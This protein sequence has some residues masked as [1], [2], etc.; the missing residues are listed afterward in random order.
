MK[1]DPNNDSLLKQA[2]EGKLPVEDTAAWQALLEKDA[3]W[4]GTLRILQQ[5]VPAVLEPESPEFFTQRILEQI[6]AD[7]PRASSAAKVTQPWW[8]RLRSAWLIP[9]GTAA[10]L[11]AA[12]VFLLPKKSSQTQT[13]AIYTPDPSVRATL[14]FH[15]E[16]NATV[17]DVQNVS[18]QDSVEI[19]PFSVASSPA[20]ATPGMPLHFYANDDPERLVFVMNAGPGNSPSIRII[21]R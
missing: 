5:H 6:R 15:E 21:E 8:Q 13:T 1:N 2:L 7:A 18:L 17:L 9:A 16:A 3:T 4:P 19:R 20:P 10:A 11:V 12:A 14:V